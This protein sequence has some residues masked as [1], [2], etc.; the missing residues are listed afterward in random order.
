MA[1]RAVKGMGRSLLDPSKIAD[2]GFFDQKVV[3]K[4]WEN[5]KL[6]I[7]NNEHRLW[8][9][10]MFQAWYSHHMEASSKKGLDYID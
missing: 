3:T 9:I 6:G 4:I 7:E 1:S 8:N 5:H 2:E 10:L